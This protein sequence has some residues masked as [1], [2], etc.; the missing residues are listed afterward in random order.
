MKEWIKEIGIGFIISGIFFFSLFGPNILMDD[1]AQRPEMR[2]E[3]VQEVSRERPEV[4]AI[5]VSVEIPHVMAV[6][7]ETVKEAPIEV[8]ENIASITEKIGEQYNI[9]PELLQAIAW[10]E[11]R[12]D[13]TAVNA[14]G[15]CYGIMQVSEKWHSHRMEAG[16]NLLDPETNIRVA[17]EYLAE[18]FERYEDPAIVLMIYNG[19][20]QWKKEWYVSS[21]AEEIL[22]MANALEK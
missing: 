22:E 20:S 16:E 15:T 1:E 21:Y 11:S 5:G 7:A 13:E 18:L 17:A 9:C 10:R 8:P 6:E 2:F 4:S 19:D 3:T 14:A 12:F